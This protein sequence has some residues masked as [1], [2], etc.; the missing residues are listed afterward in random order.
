LV[1]HANDGAGACVDAGFSAGAD[2]NVAADGRAIAAA[3]TAASRLIISLRLVQ[4]VQL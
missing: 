1:D 2:A 3:A 4:L